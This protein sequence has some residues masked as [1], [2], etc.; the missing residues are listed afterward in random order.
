MQQVGATLIRAHYPLNPQM[1]EMADQDGILLWYE[2]PVW[3]VASRYLNQPAWLTYAHSVL[4]NNILT[5]QNHPSI[6]LWSIA[7]ELPTPA[8]HA[9]AMYIAGRRRARAQARPDPPGRH[10]DQRLAGRR[11]ARRRTSRST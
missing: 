1:E 3:G 4:Q 6:L 8:T 2:I 11:R 7:N 10:G 5:N 9:E